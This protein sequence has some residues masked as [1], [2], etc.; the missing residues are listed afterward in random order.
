MSNLATAVAAMPGAPLSSLV[1]NLA[2]ALAPVWLALLVLA[3]LGAIVLL[4][5]QDA[6]HFDADV[7]EIR[8]VPE[9][10]LVEEMIGERQLEPDQLAHRAASPDGCFSREHRRTKCE[11]GRSGPHRSMSPPAQTAKIGSLLD[12]ASGT[13]SGSPGAPGWLPVRPTICAEASSAIC[14]MAVPT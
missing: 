12:L 10:I 6:R 13:G 1:M 3:V 9:G 5:G 2:P 7:P 11:Q 14:S 4:V 8:A